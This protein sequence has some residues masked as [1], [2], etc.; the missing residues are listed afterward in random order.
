MIR[1]VSSVTESLPLLVKLVT[2]VDGD[3]NNKEVIIVIIVVGAA[4]FTG[5]N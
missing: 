2:S 1:P 5:A 4:T 3:D